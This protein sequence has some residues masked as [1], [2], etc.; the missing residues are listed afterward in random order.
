MNEKELLAHKVR[1]VTLPQ[2]NTT[3]DI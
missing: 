1:T 3:V 2:R